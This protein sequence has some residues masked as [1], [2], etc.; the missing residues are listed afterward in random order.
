MIQP[1]QQYREEFV[2]TQEQVKEFARFSGDNNPI[3]LNAEYAAATPFKKPIM[4]GMIGAGVISRVFGIK[5]PGEGTIYMSQL[6]EFK[7]PM[8]VDVVYEAVITVKSVDREKHT[9]IFTTEVIDKATSKV[10]IS[11]EAHMMNKEKI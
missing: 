11:G 4:H 7:R 5:F 3:H 9:G 10:C 6:L 2:Y 1:E 8:F